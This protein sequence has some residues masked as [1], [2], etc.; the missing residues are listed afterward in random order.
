LLIILLD[1]NKYSPKQSFISS[2]YCSHP[3]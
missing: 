1:F 2:N 3:F